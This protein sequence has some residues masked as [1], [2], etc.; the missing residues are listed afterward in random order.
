MNCYIG[1]EAKSL[2]YNL[3]VK[4]E[5]FIINHIN[6]PHRHLKELRKKII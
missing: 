3:S 5:Y 4:P 2:E 1:E 6:K